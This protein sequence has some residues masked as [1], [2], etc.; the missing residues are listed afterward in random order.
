M[1][2]FSRQYDSYRRFVFTRDFVISATVNLPGK[3]A[4]FEVLDRR[5]GYEV[6]E[7]ERVDCPMIA[8]LRERLRYASEVRFK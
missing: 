1:C 5:R 7:D 2:F 3:R 8:E 4:D 6:V